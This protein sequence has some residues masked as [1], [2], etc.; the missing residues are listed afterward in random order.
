MGVW[1]L[2]EKARRRI[3]DAFLK[4]VK[5]FNPILIFAF[6]VG[7]LVAYEA[8][9]REQGAAKDLALV[10]LACPLGT[11]RIR[12]TFGGRIGELS[13]ARLWL[14]FF[15]PSDT[16]FATPLR[17]KEHRFEDNFAEFEISFPS[18][19]AD[20]EAVEEYLNHVRTRQDFWRFVTRPQRKTVR[21][22][23]VAELFFKR[24]PERLRALLVGINE[25]PNRDNRLLGCVSDVYLM[26]AVLQERGFD[27][28]SIAA[29]MNERATSVHVREKLHWLLD[30]AGE[31]D[32]RIFYFSG[33]G[34]VIPSVDSA[35]T[36]NVTQEAL[37]T[38]DFDWSLESSINDGFLTELYSQL[39]F[40]ASLVVIL[41]CG[42]PGI[43]GEV[44][45]R[46]TRGLNP[47]EDV[48]HSLLR[49]NAAEQMWVASTFQRRGGVSLGRGVSV[50]PANL[51][52]D[53]RVLQDPTTQVKQKGLQQTYHHNGPY[54]PIVMN[55]CGP[56]ELCLEFRHG[57]T[58]YGA[59]TLALSMNLRRLRFQR[60]PTT[61]ERLIIDV[62]KTLRTLGL[63]QT[64]GLAGPSA[65]FRAVRF[66]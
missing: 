66:V 65:A 22:S 60:K 18:R 44:S 24:R 46:G 64:P 40:S 58:W 59:F 3:S 41:D 20:S 29:V 32:E 31:N 2:D 52:V 25:Y 53:W 9:A 8:F 33:H 45:R 19:S 50:L 1:L 63:E 5:T 42:F 7:A 34:A 51:S 26:S 6:S 14:N 49:W 55:A 27:S 57:T 15:N 48:Q 28:E 13:R 56:R 11:P 61:I 30:D 39:P 35:E 10:T 37:A 21:K 16:P 62:H 47:P 54:L 4:D 17:I 12:A 38:Y 36:T 43:A 23:A